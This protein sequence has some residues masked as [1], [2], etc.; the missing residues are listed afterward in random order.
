MK[1]AYMIRVYADTQT[2][3]YYSP[4]HDDRECATLLPIPDKKIKNPPSWVDPRNVLDICTGRKL[5]DFMPIGEE[6]PLHRDPRLDLGFYTEPLGRK[7]RVPR[8]ATRGWLLVFVSGLAKYPRGFW[9]SRRSRREIR[10][11]Y[12]EAKRSAAAGVYIVG[13]LSVEEVLE[14]KDWE[15]CRDPRI[16]FSPHRLYSE[17]VRAFVGTSLL[18]TPPLPIETLKN[19]FLENRIES[20][21]R[22]RY[23]IGPLGPAGPVHD[24][25]M[26]I[27]ETTSRA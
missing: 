12:G 26:R 8:A 3:G 25:I 9:S 13:L 4:L 6:W 22:G 24:I 10:R 21:S 14:V 7:S 27:H 20:L 16:Q 15:N 1:L 23:R 18:L 11:A 17:P 2:V 19:S 5:V